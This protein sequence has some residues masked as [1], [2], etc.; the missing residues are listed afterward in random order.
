MSAGE[1]ESGATHSDLS[2]RAGDVVQARDIAGGIHFH[3]R[4]QSGSSS[5]PR[6]LPGD[7]RGFV[8]RVADLERLD[9]V[10]A[11]EGGGP[12][13]ASVCVI[14]GTAGVGKTSLAVHW[15]RRTRERYPDGQLY[16]NL[17]G[18]DPGEPVTAIQAL[19]RFLTAL[20]V[21]P[22]AIPTDLEANSA[23]YRSQLADKRI[24]VVLDN[25]ASVGQVRPLL[26]GADGCLALI[27]SRS[28][29][30]GLVARDGAHRVTLDVFPEPE[31]IQL[32]R[33]T[34]DG[35]R[36]GDK[37]GEIAELARL[38]ARLPLALRIAAERAAARPHMP[39]T[40][41][42]QDLRDESS[43]WDVLSSEDDEEAD[44]VR[45]VFAW[46]YRALS[47][48]AA[49]MFRLLGVHP[50]PGFGTDAAA[51]L[52]DV[53]VAQ[54]RQLLDVLVGAHLLEQVGNDRYQFHDLLRAYAND[55][56]GHEEA[57][58]DRL[59]ALRRCCSWYLYTMDA[60]RSAL[61]DIILAGPNL[62][63]DNE[64]QALSFASPEQALSW[65]ETEAD[66]L[67]MASQ[68]A[69]VEGLYEIAWQLSVVT[70]VSYVVRRPYSNWLPV[71]LNALICARR[72]GDRLGEASTLIALGTSYRFLRRTPEAIESDQL[73]RAVA[74]DIGDRELEALALREL[75]LAQIVGRHF[76]A[77]HES[78]DQE[79]ALAR[80]VGDTTRAV[81]VGYISGYALFEAGHIVEAHTS[82]LQLF[83]ALPAD[84]PR[85][86]LPDF[87]HELARVQREMGQPEQALK[88]VHA[89]LKVARED[90]KGSEGIYEVEHGRILIALGQLNDALIS[91]QRAALILRRVGN[92]SSEALALDATGTAYQV[93]GRLEEAADFHRR[94]AAIHRDLDDKWNLA[95]ALRNLATALLVMGESD[96]AVGLHDA[97][98]QLIVGYTDA[99]AMALRTQVAEVLEAFGQD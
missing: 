79:L 59:A 21:P 91:L 26:P 66:N 68:K 48:D 72:I 74:R 38:C 61:G 64:A 40:A 11:V 51:A 19:E 81:T 9:A 95:A 49:R 87:N 69:S 12:G 8:N 67:I 14:A 44:A 90:G 76:D 29:L 65:F 77:A 53:F 88:F 10:L 70:F 4:G 16:V 30:S 63:P 89:A 71:G 7:V 3:G 99:R 52:A 98:L 43:L 35:Y 17:R 1:G 96:E 50:G 41:L 56:A 84:Y 62:L 97:V 32:L 25:A 39:L 60:A 15:A 18:Y 13:T 20:G 31:A 55:Q 54:A 58:E 22:G 27:T 46:S 47:P 94:A 85:Y 57:L 37:D 45:T 28:R 6:Q 23:L 73:A 33:A 92:R 36:T 86:D 78:L 93:L 42:I 5:V 75:G 82:L 34:T 83:E 80:E 2:G 24:L